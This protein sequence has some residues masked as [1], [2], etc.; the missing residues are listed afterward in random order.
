MT[1]LSLVLYSGVHVVPAAPQIPE[2]LNITVLLFHII[3]HHFLPA[4][5]KFCEPLD[6][7][8]P[9]TL[10]L[11]LYSGVHVVPAAPQIPE[12]LNIT[13]LFSHIIVHPFLPAVPILSEPLEMMMPHPR[14]FQS[15]SHCWEYA[16]HKCWDPKDGELCLARLKS[17]EPL[18]EDR[19]DS[20][21]QIDR[22]SWV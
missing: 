16:E 19:S 9:R 22:R 1:T 14:D 21:V 15:T 11:V 5:P 17:G 20:A 10:S 7:L 18:M 3:V 8:I 4:V 12:A 13:V 6:I 2:A